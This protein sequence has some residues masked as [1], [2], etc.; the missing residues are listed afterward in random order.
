MAWNDLP[1]RVP[2]L[3][4]F[5]LVYF[6]ALQKKIKVFMS[7]FLVMLTFVEFN[8][9]QFRQYLLWVVVFIPFLLVDNW[10]RD[11]VPATLENG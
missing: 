11:D 9:V 5:V 4:M 3:F 1:A 7:A 6:A 2:M 8:P 10:P